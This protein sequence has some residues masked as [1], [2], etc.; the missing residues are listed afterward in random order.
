MDFIRCTRALTVRSSRFTAVFG[1]AVFLLFALCAVSARAQTAPPPGPT[2]PQPIPP[3]VFITQQ[4]SLD[5]CNAW[6]EWK[7][8][9][10]NVDDGMDNG[11]GVFTPCTLFVDGKAAAAPS[12]NTP[13]NYQF[14]QYIAGVNWGYVGADDFY[15]STISGQPEKNLGKG[16][17][18]GCHNTTMVGEPINAS[19][20]NK[21]LREDDIQ[22]GPWLSF[23]RFY[24][25]F[26]GSVGA[27][28]GAYW[29]DSFDSELNIIGSPATSIGFT[30]PDGMVEVFTKTNGV[31]TSDADV[32]DVLNE[33]DNAQ[34]AATSYTVFL[35][36]EHRAETFSTAGLLQSVTDPSGEGITLTYN[37]VQPI[38]QLVTVT[39]S[40]GRQLHVTYNAVGAISQITLPERI[41]LASPPR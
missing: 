12:P 25:N 21:Y 34:G 32:N 29:R 9:V 31:W 33:I 20:G 39:D 3:A 16:K 7:N 38:P 41:H 27:S 8:I 40:T 28:I 13:G 19:T 10:Y 14:Q 11:E 30:Q 17:P 2:S 35:A 37:T 4:Q 23:S 18:C 1:V 26:A 36:A 24:N 6:R 5:Y 22:I 15:Y